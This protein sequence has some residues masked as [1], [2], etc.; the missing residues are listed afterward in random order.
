M[1]AL[2][3][4]TVQFRWI[5]WSH[6]CSPV[7]V[8]MHYAVEYYDLATKKGSQLISVYRWRD[9][10]N[11][12]NQS[13]VRTRFKQG[14][15][16]RAGN[17]YRDIRTVFFWNSPLMLWLLCLTEFWDCLWQK[18]QLDINSTSLFSS[19]N[20]R[21][22]IGIAI[23]VDLFYRAGQVSIKLKHWVRRNTFWLLLLPAVTKTL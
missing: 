16:T 21:I 18:H 1:V 13:A 20:G 5:G 7:N 4:F 22:F 12:V 11:C 15:T 17:S 23:S 8:C 3:C 9:R 10:S 14:R 6:K 19:G 2:D